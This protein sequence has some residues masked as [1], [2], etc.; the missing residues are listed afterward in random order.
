MA[1]TPPN[2]TATRIT[3]SC[4]SVTWSE[5]VAF[6][7]YEVFYGPINE[8]KQSVNTTNNQGSQLTSLLGNETYEIYVVAFGDNNTLPSRSNTVEVL[9][10]ECDF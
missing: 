2:I 10:G 9:Q 5:N 3:P 7:L 6:D 1:D 8:I 4:I